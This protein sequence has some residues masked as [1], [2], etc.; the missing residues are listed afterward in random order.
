ALE[1]SRPEIR[2]AR[3]HGRAQRVDGDDGGDRVPGLRDVA[4]R[5]DAAAQ[6]GG[7]G[8]VARAATAE[9]EWS[10]PGVRGSRVAELTVRRVAAP[11]LV[12][13]VVEIEADCR[14]NDRYAGGA[15]LEAAAGLAQPH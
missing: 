1:R 3:E 11:V 12:A 4:R 7:G 15:D 14:R 6:V 2:S 13:A 5:A 9:R 10:G 8:T